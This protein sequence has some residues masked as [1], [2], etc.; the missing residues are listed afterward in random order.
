M[1]EVEHI[2]I[3]NAFLQPWFKSNNNLC[4]KCKKDFSENKWVSG[5]TYKGIDFHHNP[6]QFMF[7]NLDDWEGDF[8]E[9]CRDCHKELHKEILKIM[10]E[11][12]NLFKFKNSEYWTWKAITNKTECRNNIYEFTNKWVMNKELHAELNHNGGKHNGKS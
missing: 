4:Q 2:S 10:F 12:S 7:E 3:K 6:P 5:E 1:N 11:H 8:L 9:L